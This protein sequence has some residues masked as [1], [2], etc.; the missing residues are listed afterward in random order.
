VGSTILRSSAALTSILVPVVVRRRT[1]HCWGSWLPSYLI[2][3]EWP[4]FHV[5]R[6]QHRES[7]FR[8]AHHPAEVVNVSFT[9]YFLHQTT[10]RRFISRR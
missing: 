9:L 2:R 1:I 5:V 3:L 4:N 8:A 6:G 10:N 7:V